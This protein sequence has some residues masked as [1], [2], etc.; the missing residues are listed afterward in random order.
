[1]HGVILFEIRI[2]ILIIFIS[3]SHIGKCSG[4]LILVFTNSQ[5]YRIVFLPIELTNVI[6]YLQNLKLYL[7]KIVFPCQAYEDIIKYHLN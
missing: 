7:L 6:Y 2:Y 4:S 5:Q 1:M 3:L